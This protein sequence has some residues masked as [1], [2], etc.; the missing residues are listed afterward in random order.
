MSA[1]WNHAP[2][3]GSPECRADQNNA[4]L[5]RRTP[6]YYS[7]EIFQPFIQQMLIVRE[8][9]YRQQLNGSDAKAFDVIHRGFIAHTVISAAHF[10]RYRRLVPVQL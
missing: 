2:Y 10:G 7:P 5:G 4:S 6:G 1:S 3:R 8:P 9:V